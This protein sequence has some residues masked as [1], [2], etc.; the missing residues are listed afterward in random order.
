MFPL[1]VACVERLF[2]K[3]KLI[4][5]CLRNQLGKTTLGSLLQ[6]STESTIGFDDDKY[7]YFVDEL[8]RLNPQMRIKL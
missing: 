7:E 3:T 5:T 6:I 2:S 4:K 1:R 8:K